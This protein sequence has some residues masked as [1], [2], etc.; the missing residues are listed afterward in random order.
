MESKIE[1]NEG[2]GENN[3]ELDDI[4]KGVETSLVMKPGRVGGGTLL[5]GNTGSKSSTQGEQGSSEDEGNNLGS[6]ATRAKG[7][8]DTTAWPEETKGHNRNR[9]ERQNGEEGNG[10]EL[11]IPDLGERVGIQGIKAVDNSHDDHDK[12]SAHRAKQETEDDLARQAPSNMRVIG[13]QQALGE[14][15]IDDEEQNDTGVCKYAG[16]D[17]DAGVGRMDSPDDT[18]C[19]CDDSSHGEAETEC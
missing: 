18:Q 8:S 14:Y 6:H 3:N 13:T 16:G 15:K 12:R 9:E 17:G 7:I 11:N 2:I 10:K 19:V 1:A 4:I 5:E